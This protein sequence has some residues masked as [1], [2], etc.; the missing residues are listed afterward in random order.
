M[1]DESTVDGRYPGE[2]PTLETIWCEEDPNTI[3]CCACGDRIHPKPLMRTFSIGPRASETTQDPSRKI[4]ALERAISIY[5]RHLECA[6]RAKYVA[7]S[8][9]WNKTVSNVQN[10]K[11]SPTEKE[12]ARVLAFELPLRIYNGMPKE[13]RERQE[14]WHDY[15]SVPQ[16][17]QNVKQEILGHVASIFQQASFTLVHLDDVSRQSIQKMRSGKSLRERADGVAHICNAT[18]FSRV[19]TAMEYVRSRDTRPM[20][21]DYKLFE[22]VHDLF[23]AELHDTW[24]H[25]VNE[26]GDVHEAERM[27]KHGLVPWQLG[28][29]LQLKSWNPASFAEAFSMLSKRGCRGNEDFFYALDGI[30]KLRWG[31]R[32]NY[33]NYG[34]ACLE[35]A[36]KCIE[37]GDYTPLLMSRRPVDNHPGG[38]GM[39][40][41]DAG[42]WSLGALECAPPVEA[43]GLSLSPFGNPVLKAEKIGTV[44]FI[45]KLPFRRLNPEQAFMHI[46]RVSIDFTGPDVDAF[47]ATIGTRMYGQSTED[48]QDRLAR[49]GRRAQLERELMKRF[50]A[51]EGQAPWLETNW[52]ADTLGLSSIALDSCGGLPPMRFMKAHGGT[53]HLGPHGALVG[54]T[55]QSCYGSFIFRAALYVPPSEVRG[56]TAYRIPGLKYSSTLKDGVAVLVRE[57]MIVGRMVWAVPA[58]QCRMVGDV[59]VQLDEFPARKIHLHRPNIT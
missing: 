33:E 21:E 41:H 3:T 42:M 9:V 5:N 24:H 56:A 17:Q 52:I 53:L 37:A 26:R 50:N 8:H 59:E 44:T 36:R 55:C 14:M 49:G 54:V 45:R 10:G 39:G 57:C 40:Y 1:G 32:P 46:A 34:M 7:V 29:L 38:I 13:V 11:G 22:G 31:K 16:W 2:T 20:L 12:E 4:S 25:I 6:H 30:L 18:W 28:P 23:I 58:C 51:Q 27:A 48:I 35:I 47:A 15:I 19:W 43:K